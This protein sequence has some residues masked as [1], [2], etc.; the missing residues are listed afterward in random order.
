MTAIQRD[1]LSTRS[2]LMDAVMLAIAV[3]AAFVL[4][5]YRRRDIAKFPRTTRVLKKIGVFPI[6]DHY[7]EPMFNDS[8]LTRPLSDDRDLPGIDLNVDGQCT[9]M[10]EVIRAGGEGS[11]NHDRRLDAPA[12]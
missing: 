1:N 6:I 11:G 4:R 2:R 5:A 8:S 3:P 9:G 10:G 12:I 7:Y